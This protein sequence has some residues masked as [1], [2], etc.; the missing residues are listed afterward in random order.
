[1]N[2]DNEIIGTAKTVR[3]TAIEVVKGEGQ[4]MQ[5]PSQRDIKLKGD[6]T[7]D[8]KL[9]ASLRR[10]HAGLVAEGYTVEWATL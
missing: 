9:C 4:S 10:M 8:A 2:L 7:W 3:F 6:E 1:M 5:F